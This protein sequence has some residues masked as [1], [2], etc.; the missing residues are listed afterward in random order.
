VPDRTV[1]VIARQDLD[2]WVERLL[3]YAE[4]VAPVRAA[5]GDTLFA[6]IASPAEVLWQFE[7]P[8]LPPK[9]VLL[10]QTEHLARIR[11]RNGHHEVEPAPAPGPRV[12]LNARSCDT[13]ALAYLRRMLTEEP[14]DTA[15]MRRA[16]TLAV[17][18][19]AC[20][21][22]CSHGFCTCCDAGPFLR[23]DYDL[24][25][26]DL[27][28]S[29]FVEVGSEKGQALLDLAP[30]LFRA[31]SA[32]A[33]EARARTEDLA[34]A[35]LGEETC[36]FGSAMRRISTNR[37]PDA[38][39]E[40]MSPWCLECGG[41]TLACPTCYCFSVGDHTEADGTDGEGEDGTCW[42]RCRTWDSCQYS[43][44]TLEASGHNPRPLHRDRIKRRFFHKTSAQ[45]MKRDGRLGCVGCGRCVKVCMGTTD[46]PAVVHAVR[47]GTWDM[48]RP[49]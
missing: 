17:V 30:S 5:Q 34:R 18:T 10:P 46:M 23:E 6:T 14:A 33:V 8:L 31:A 3:E 40:A 26:T 24:Q 28:A 35:S 21:R 20:H 13:T 27:G 7:N 1:R 38:L 15:V 44:F 43:A 37:V 29:L 41:C 16:D 11:R 9:S 47:K 42:V 12:L 39:W 25:L 22:P 32:A 4:V 48:G 36:H 2:G 49:L 45:Y 19:L